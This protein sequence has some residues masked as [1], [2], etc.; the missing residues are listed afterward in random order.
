MFHG[1]NNLL[2]SEFLYITIILRE[3]IHNL[4]VFIQGVY[5]QLT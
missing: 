4:A 2:L 1:S 5:L 3:P